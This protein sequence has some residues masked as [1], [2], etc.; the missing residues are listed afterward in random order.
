MTDIRPD[1][2][3]HL[4]RGDDEV[5]LRDAARELVHALLGDLDAALAVEEVGAER[6]R[7]ADGVEAGIAPLGGRLP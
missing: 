2:P 4:V 3:V 1:A 6:F 7:P 5:I